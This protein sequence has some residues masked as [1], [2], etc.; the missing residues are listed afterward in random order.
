MCNRH[1]TF[2][3]GTKCAGVGG[4]WLR[5]QFWNRKHR[6]SVYQSICILNSNADAS[7]IWSQREVTSSF[8][9][10]SAEVATLSLPRMIFTFFL[11]SSSSQQNSYRRFKHSFL[12]LTFSLNIL[13]NAMLKS[14]G[15]FFCGKWNRFIAADSIQCI[16]SCR[17]LYII[18]T[19][20]P[21]FVLDIVCA[22]AP[23][24]NNDD[25]DVKKKTKNHPNSPME[26]KTL[27][28]KNWKRMNTKEKR[29]KGTDCRHKRPDRN[30]YYGVLRKNE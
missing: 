3:I 10:F 19:F 13:R 16:C 20:F 22:W 18:R 30:V 11:V 26:R 21:L 28:K 23:I 5:E 24:N 29:W 12:K 2:W 17:Y 1:K 15:I 6:K 9:S 4:K 14:R 8:N 27:E 7:L 25:D